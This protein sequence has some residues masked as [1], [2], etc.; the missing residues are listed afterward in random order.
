MCLLFLTEI[1][2]SEPSNNVSSNKKNSN[3]SKKGPSNSENN[4]TSANVLST[5]KNNV[6]SADVPPKSLDESSSD[7]DEGVIIHQSFLPNNSGGDFHV[8][9]K[10][11][12]E[13]QILDTRTLFRDHPKL[14]RSYY[15]KKIL[16]K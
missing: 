14:V 6:A 15:Q 10:N 4:V 3:S 2:F 1:A 7:D 16:G 11:N 13:P 8:Q 5:S 12:K 9:W